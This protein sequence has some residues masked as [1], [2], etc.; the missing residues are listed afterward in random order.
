MTQCHTRSMEVLKGL[1]GG[2]TPRSLFRALDVAGGD[3]RLSKSF[4]LSQYSKV[5]IFDQCPTAVTKARKALLGHSRFGYA[6]QST[7]QDFDWRFDYSGIFMVWVVGYLADS[8]L[9]SFLRKAKTKLMPG[10]FR[11]TRQE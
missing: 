2:I 9:V 11:T 3:G 8:A 5:D 7:M 1:L 10:R 4:L 6:A